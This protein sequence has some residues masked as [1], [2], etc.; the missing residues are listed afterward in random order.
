MRKSVI[1]PMRIFQ[2][3]EGAAAASS[4]KSNYIKSEEN[5]A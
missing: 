3:G 4:L 1:L 5:K 2:P